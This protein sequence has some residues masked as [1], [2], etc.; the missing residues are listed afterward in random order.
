VRCGT[1]SGGGLYTAPAS[2][3][4]PATLT[5]SATSV[6]VKKSKKL[7]SKIIDPIGDTRDVRWMHMD[8]FISWSGPRSG[9][10]AN[11]L[12]SWLPLIIN[13]LKPFLSSADIDKGA[14]WGTE[15][16]QR[17]Q[18]A[19]AGIICLTPSNISSEWLLFETGALSKTVANTFVCPLLI[20]LEPSDIKGPLAQFQATRATKDELL[21]LV[22]TLNRALEDA[23]LSDSQIEDAFGALWPKLETALN[24]LPPDEPRAKPQREERDILE[25]ILDLVRNQSRSAAKALVGEDFQK[26]LGERANE[27]LIS[28]GL[29]SGTATF[30]GVDK[31]VIGATLRVGGKHLDVVVPTNTPLEAVEGMVKAQLPA[32]PPPAAPPNFPAVEIKSL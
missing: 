24:N 6:A 3:P 31:I 12:R 15:L 17:L 1:I 29:V 19:K 5:V 23:A 13:A 10:V 2:V 30:T 32:P 27:V 22:K 4:S 7:K 26:A 14:R 28:S 18:A 21:K 16:A 25:E 8:V 11:A 20:G 9:A